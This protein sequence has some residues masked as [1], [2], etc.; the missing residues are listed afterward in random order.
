MQDRFFDTNQ[1][2]T[3]DGIKSVIRVTSQERPNRLLARVETL[4]CG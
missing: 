4:R 2:S 1:N 3:K